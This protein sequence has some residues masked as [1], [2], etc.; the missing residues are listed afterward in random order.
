MDKSRENFLIIDDISK[1][2]GVVEALKNVSFTVSK[3][4]VHSLLGENGAGK[5]TLIKIIKGEETPTSGSITLDGIKIKTYTPIAA[6]NLGIAMVHQELAI[7][8]NMTVAENIFPTCDFL[9]KTGALD[10]KRLMKEAKNKIDLF[11]MN[12]IPNQ[13]MDTLTVAQQQMTEIL[14]AISAGSKCVLLDEPTSGLNKEETTKLMS[15]IDTLRN[16][17]ITIIY[18]SHRISEVMQISDR[19]TVLRDGEY[20]CTFVND[21]NLTEMDLISKMVGRELTDSLYQR[22]KYS[23]IVGDE[24]YFE[25]KGMSKKNAAY[26]INFKL[27]T[28]EVIGFF[29]LEGSGTD[30]VSRM[31]FGLEAMDSGEVYFKGEKIDKVN[32]TNM[33]E[34]KIMYINNNRKQA[35]L[36][37]NSSTLNNMSMPV[38]KEYAKNTF[39]DE[40]RLIKHTEKYVSAFNVIIPS[41]YQKPINLS[42]GNQQKVLL[43]ICL[44]N[45][46]ELMIINEP[47]RGIDVGAK[48]EIHKFLLEAVDEGVGMIVFSSELPELMSLCDRIIVMKNKRFVGEVRNEEISEEFIM[49]IAAGGM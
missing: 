15:I 36:L 34:K 48:A 31:I 39:I 10:T 41:V 11:G 5:S 38:L 42:G 26:D 8:E 35:G 24:V 16:Q 43:S 30:S 22:K 1:N 28:G 29:G 45:N 27:K 17:G 47:T 46:P 7:F 44:G 14:R 25:V 19:I 3:G 18:I 4:E 33:V 12:L 23:E 2:Y 49:K 6:R 13:K 21:S 37:L 20:V 40:K 32:T 9:T